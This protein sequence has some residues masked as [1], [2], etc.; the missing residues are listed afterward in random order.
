MFSQTRVF[1]QKTVTF[2]VKKCLLDFKYAVFKL[3][4]TG[5]A[6]N[7]RYFTSRRLD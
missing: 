3:P 2:G 1:Q 4:L 7:T 6:P 5:W